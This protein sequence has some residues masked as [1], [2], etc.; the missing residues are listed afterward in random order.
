MMSTMGRSTGDNSN[1]RKQVAI[2]DAIHEDPF[3]EAFT[4]AG[5]SE[6]ESDQEHR[7]SHKK[8]EKEAE[9]VNPEIKE[10]YK[11]LAALYTRAGTDHSKM[12]AYTFS[13]SEA[14]RDSGIA[15]SKENTH[16]HTPHN[17]LS[18]HITSPLL[19]P[20]LSSSSFGTL[21][22][23]STQM[24]S[25]HSSSST[26]SIL[27][28]SRRTSFGP[29]MLSAQAKQKTISRRPS[30]DFASFK[31]NFSSIEMWVTCDSAFTCDCRLTHETTSF[32]QQPQ[33]AQQSSKGS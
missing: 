21:S 25:L 11:S 2:V 9:D 20:L 16:P 7:T 13:P 17:E 27:S 32:L 33:Q 3:R 4:A 29:A 31:V 24:T 5:W 15:L 8:Q 28:S 1:A 14:S 12:D 22:T 6:V 23:S 26:G 19:S 10:L 30:A 18:D